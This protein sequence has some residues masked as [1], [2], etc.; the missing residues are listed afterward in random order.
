MDAEPA[1]VRFVDVAD[2]WASDNFGKRVG[3]IR[4]MTAKGDSM[5]GAGINSGDLLFVDT[6]QQTWDGDGFYIVQFLNGWQVKRLRAD[7]MSQQLEIVS[8]PVTGSE[9]YV[10]PTERLGELR[11]GG[12]ISAWW[13]L[14][15]H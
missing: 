2:Q 3:H 11:I 15:H 10:V 12:K 4:V 14:R 8:M 9:P 5:V 6:S 13:T 7:I 1:V